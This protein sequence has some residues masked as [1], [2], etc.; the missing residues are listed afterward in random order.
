MSLCSKTR[1][2]HRSSLHLVA[3][4]IAALC[5]TIAAPA[6]AQEAPA[7]EATAPEAPPPAPAPAPPPSKP[8]SVTPKES[9]R[10]D[11][12][13]PAPSTAERPA[14]DGS[15][16]PARRGIQV[17][18]R[19]GAA[20]PMGQL[21]GGTSTVYDNP[22]LRQTNDLSRMYGTQ[23]VVLLE[24]GAKVQD[25]IFVGGYLGGGLGGS[26]S[27]FQSACGRSG[28]SCLTSLF[29]LGFEAQ[30]HFIPDGLFN[31]WVGVGLG[32]E[33]A[34]LHVR[35]PGGEAKASAS[36]LELADLMIGAD[37]RLTQKIGIGP[38]LSASAAQYSTAE[39]ESN[40]TTKSGDIGDK[41]I[42]SWFN[43]GARAVFFP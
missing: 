3:S 9:P 5:T 12:P 24:I 6:L 28:V 20:L 43:L 13:A 1:L 32:Y 37:V 15:P 38:V 30:Y 16:P 35:G 10:S 39:L 25:H 19:A 26:G 18:L 17:G 34:S 27:D 11:P 36:G 29:R 22:N 40:G 21:E 42:H 8:A 31:P 7:P 14:D 2:T 33:S 4:A 23:G 41:A